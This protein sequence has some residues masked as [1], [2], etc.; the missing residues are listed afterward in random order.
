MNDETKQM[1]KSAFVIRNTMNSE[2]VFGLQP[3]QSFI[4]SIVQLKSIHSRTG[5]YNVVVQQCST[6]TT[7]AK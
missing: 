2:D 4:F 6:S 5:C 7:T 3:I 1:E